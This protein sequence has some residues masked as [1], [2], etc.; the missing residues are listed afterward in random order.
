MTVTALGRVNV[1]SPGTPV[2]LSADSELRISKLFVQ[3]IPGLTGKGYVGTEDLDKSTLDGVVRV[4]WPNASGGFSDQFA[5]ESADGLNSMHLAE[6]TIDMD[7]ADEG[8]LVSYW[9]A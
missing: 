7:V 1:A 4:L 5:I 6:Y 3:V 8:L 2:R 9:V